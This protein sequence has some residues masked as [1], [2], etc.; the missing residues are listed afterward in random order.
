MIGGTVSP[1]KPLGGM[2]MLVSRF[3]ARA[4]SGALFAAA[5]RER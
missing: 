4:I 5:A 2:K 3:A 1:C